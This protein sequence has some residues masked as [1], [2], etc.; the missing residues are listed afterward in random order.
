MIY[1]TGGL[2][3]AH[4]VTTLVATQ[5]VSGTVVAALPGPFPGVLGTVPFS[6]TSSVSAQSGQT[7]LGWSGG[8][9]ADWK[10]TPNII[11]G[12]LYLHY[13]FPDHTLAFGSSGIG[14]VNLSNTRQSVDVVKA[15][16][17]YQ[18]PIH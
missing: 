2:A 18:I 14:A 5:T 11:L 16:L 13:E 9:G 17:S 12:L 6:T 10:A 3:W 7:L 1:G 15:R 4:A 8:V